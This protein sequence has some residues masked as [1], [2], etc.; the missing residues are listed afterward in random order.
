MNHILDLTIIAFAFGPFA[1]VAAWGL[2]ATIRGLIPRRQAQ[3][4]ALSQY[5]AVRGLIPRRKPDPNH[6]TAMAVIRSMALP[7]EV[8][9]LGR[10]AAECEF[11]AAADDTP[12]WEK[13]HLLASAAFYRQ[14][15]AV[16]LYNYGAAKEHRTI[17]KAGQPWAN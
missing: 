1:V 15:Q 11:W 9:N 6:E 10:L 14:E 13:P 16:I 5:P 4:Q 3:C 7:P 12:H 2:V 17:A 8:E